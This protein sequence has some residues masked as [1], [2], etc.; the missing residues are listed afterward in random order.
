MTDLWDADLPLWLAAMLRL[1][2]AAALGGLVGLEREVRGRDAGFRTFMLVCLGSAL[3]MIVSTH[4]AI[5]P[6]KAPP[7]VNIAVDPARIAYGIMAGVGFLGAGTIIHNRGS[8]RGLTTAAGIWC[9]AAL[10]LAVG[11]GLYLVS[12]LAAVLILVALWLLDYVGAVLPRLRQRTV[13]LRTRYRPGC[14]SA[15]VER[16][17]S[18]GVHVSDVTFERIGDLE[19]A[20]IHVR[21]DFANN[22]QY[23]DLPQLFEGDGEFQVL[24]AREL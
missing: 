1:A 6:W 2:V 3:A 17:K 21:V 12:I 18:A 16:F 19:H 8:V 10:G 4:F 24:S 15:A 5:H 11:F 23:Y 22:Q 13:T 20:D 9:V 14:I 7:G